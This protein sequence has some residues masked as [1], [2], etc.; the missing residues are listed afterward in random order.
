MGMFWWIRKTLQ[1][2]VHCD[3]F[4]SKARECRLYVLC[5]ACLN[6]STL[7]GRHRGGCLPSRGEASFCMSSSCICNTAMYCVLQGQE[8]GGGP[9]W[10]QPPQITQ[11]KKNVQITW[12]KQAV[13]KHLYLFI[14]VPSDFDCS[15]ALRNFKINLSSWTLSELEA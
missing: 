9:Q 15:L 10:S 14:F 8:M 12:E 7:S 4:P 13:P 11:A 2:P 6:A 5:P 1:L 3:I